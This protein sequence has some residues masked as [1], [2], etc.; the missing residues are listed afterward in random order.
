[1]GLKVVKKRLNLPDLHKPNLKDPTVVRRCNYSFKFP[2]VAYT[3]RG[4][5]SLAKVMSGEGNKVA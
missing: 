4:Y 2:G 1:M 3:F 5:Q